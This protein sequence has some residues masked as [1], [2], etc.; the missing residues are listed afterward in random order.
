M[1]RLINVKFF[2]RQL[3]NV[4]LRCL[5][6]PRDN[7]TLQAAVEVKRLRL[8]HSSYSSATG[9][10]NEV[11]VY[12]E[13]EHLQSNATENLSSGRWISEIQLY[14]FT[15]LHPVLRIDTTKRARQERKEHLLMKA[16]LSLCF[17]SAHV[18]D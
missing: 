16:R 15:C 11:E 2:K 7:S 4:A 18:S 17:A 1:R 3:I 14:R 8:T 12:A 10:S 5:A 13:A 6:L 9:K